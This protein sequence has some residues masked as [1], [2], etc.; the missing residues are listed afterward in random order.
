MDS[1]KILTNDKEWRELFDYKISRDMNLADLT[2]K[3]EARQNLELDEY[4]INK[5]DAKI[6]KEPSI[7]N[8]MCIIQDTSARFVSDNQIKWWNEKDNVTTVIASYSGGGNETVIPHGIKNNDGV[9]IAPLF[10]VAN[11]SGNPGGGLGE[12]WIRWDAENVYVGN[13]GSFTGE[14]ICGIFNHGALPTGEQEIMYTIV[15]AEDC[16]NYMKNTY[17]TTYS[18]IAQVPDEM[19]L[20]DTSS[21][22]N[23]SSMFCM[24]EKLESIPAMDTSNVIDMSYM[25]S[26]CRALISIPQLNTSSATNMGS[27]FYICPALT[28]VPEL[29]TSNATSIESMF[30]NCT[31]LPKVFPWTINCSSI[32]KIEGAKYIFKDSSVKEVTFSNVKEDLKTQFTAANLG[33]Q[34]TKINFI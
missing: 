30:R 2:N 19:Q 18:K 15:L 11:P 3:A 12:Q 32:T 31:S 5:A 21:V 7:I 13:T 17:P 27:M 26:A 33:T 20:P 9:S 16:N 8:H 14:F 29:D 28:D 25:F 4:Y 34:L 6:A 23:M 22:T 1:I 24:C 10:C